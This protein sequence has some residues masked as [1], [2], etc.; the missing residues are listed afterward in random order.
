[1]TQSSSAPPP[2]RI[3]RLDEAVVNRIAAGEII[4]RPANAIKELLENSLDAGSTSI[5]IL[6]KEGGLKVLQIQDNGHGISKDDL[7]FVCER[8]ATSK[9]TSFDDLSCI[10]TYGFRGEALASISHVAHV[11][12][13]SKTE[14]SACAWRACYSDGV[15]VPARP[16]ASADPKPTAGNVGTL[17]MIEDLFYNVPTRKKALKSAS[18]EYSKIVDIIIRYA[19]HNSKVAFTCKKIGAS[20]ADVTTSQGASQL[21]NIRLIYGAPIAKELLPINFEDDDLEFK[22]SGLI[23]NANFNLKKINLLLFI[24]HRVVDCTNLKRALEAL[25]AVYLPKNMHPFCYISLEIKPQNVDVNVHPTKREVMFLNEEKIIES[26]CDQIRDKLSNANESRTFMTQAISTVPISSLQSDIASGEKQKKAGQNKV[27][28]YMQVRTDSRV[29]TLDAFITSVPSQSGRPSPTVPSLM[30][31]LSTGSPLLARFEEREID[32]DVDV[33]VGS[34]SSGGVEG[35]YKRTTGSTRL[36][37]MSVDDVEAGDGA[38]DDQFDED[39]GHRRVA[40]KDFAEVDLENE[41]EMVVSE[42]LMAVDDVAASAA[43][44]GGCC[45]NDHGATHKET[46]PTRNSRAVD[47]AVEEGAEEEKG[48]ETFTSAMAA[49]RSGRSEIVDVLLTSVLELREEFKEDSHNGLTLL[50]KD[51]TFVGLCDE[52]MA[53]IQYQTKLFIVNFEE[54]T[55]DLFY[56]LALR[57]FNNFGFITLASPLPIKDLVLLAIEQ[58]AENSG[59]DAKEIMSTA[60]KTAEDVVENLVG[61]RQMLLEYFSIDID[62]E[63]NLTT[64]PVMLRG[65]KPYLGKL[66]MFLYRMGTEVEWT[67]EKD[68]FQGISIELGRFYAT[69]G[70]SLEDDDDTPES[71]DQEGGGGMELDLDAA[72]KKRD[73]VWAQYRWTVEHVIFKA[74]RQ[75]Y[76]PSNRLAKSEAIIQIADLPELYKVFERC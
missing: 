62:E 4:Q 71:D 63:G 27:P 38:G 73:E 70:L 20:T 51:H 45:Q 55:I 24:N 54:I 40:P 21:D 22:L 5:Q 30:P 17:I 35:S 39:G 44:H 72:K 53:L 49:R 23:S 74:L 47:R 34:S 61:Q 36:S 59:D 52:R 25:Y 37:L 75:W 33:V 66:P 28:E 46:T 3:Q 48:Q 13:T 56:Q 68:C 60:E 9:L 16:G 67:S 6:V 76:F 19:I 69:S 57:G 31:Q 11:T 7:P 26:I 65:Y 12:I 29:R 10:G 18:E 8:F 1:M 15:L 42:S 58:L 41:V 50:F 43:D 32:V 2:R 14:D 64:L